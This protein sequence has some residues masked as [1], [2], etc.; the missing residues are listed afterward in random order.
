MN[1]KRPYWHLLLEIIGP[2]QLKTYMSYALLEDTDCATT[3]YSPYNFKRNL[4]YSNPKLSEARHFHIFLGYFTWNSKIS[5]WS[6]NFNTYK[7]RSKN[8]KN[9]NKTLNFYEIARKKN[10]TNSQRGAYIPNKRCWNSCSDLKTPIKFY[11]RKF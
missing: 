10:R 6:P 4:V 2:V 7:R 8:F 1:F 9:F 5:S 11:L 3:V